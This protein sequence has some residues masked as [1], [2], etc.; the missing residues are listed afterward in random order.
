M[1]AAVAPLAPRLGMGEPTSAAT[2]GCHRDEAPR[3]AE[4]VDG[5][6]CIARLYLQNSN[7]WLK[8]VQILDRSCRLA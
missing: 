6:Q 2:C 8:H 7:V 3:K 4:K 1:T 5:D